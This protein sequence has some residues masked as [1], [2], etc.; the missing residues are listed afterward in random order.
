MVAV[1]NAWGTADANWA[2]YAFDEAGN[3]TNQVDAL[4]RVTKFQYDKL[5]RRIVRRLPSGDPEIYG[6]DSLGNMIAHTNFN[7]TVVTN[8][9]DVMNRLRERGVLNAGVQETYAYSVSGQLTNRVDESGPYSWFHDSRGRVRTNHTPMGA[10]FYDYDRNGNVTNLYSSTV[11]GVAIIY[12]YDALNR[13]TNVVDN[14]LSGVK[15]TSYRFD[16]V[17]N[18]A[19]LQYPNGVTNVWQYDTRNRLTNEVWKLNTTTLASFFYKL[20]VSSQRTNLSEVVNGTS[21]NFAWNYDQ[22]YRLTNEVAGGLGNLAYKYDVV[23]NRTNR[24]SSV[25][26]LA[27]QTPAYTTNDW[28]TADTYDLNGNTTE[29]GSVTYEYDWANRLTKA[30]YPTVIINHN[31]EGHR[32]KKLTSTGWKYYLVDT[33]NPSGYAQV[34]EEFTQNFG[35]DPVLTKVYTYGLDLISERVPDTSTNFFG[36]D[37]HGSTRFLTDAGGGVA[38]AF[39]YDA[40]GTLIAS[41]GLAQTDYLYCG[42]QFDRDLG[43]YFLRARYMKTDT[44]RFWTMDSYEGNSGDPLSL[45]KYLYCHGDS[46]NDVD[47]SGRVVGGLTETVSVSGIQANSRT[48]EGI[49]V[50]A[51]KAGATRAISGYILKTGSYGI[52]G[53]DGIQHCGTNRLCGRRSHS[54]PTRCFVAPS[55]TATKDAN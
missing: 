47:P 13:L 32:F 52:L 17:G 22:Q 48:L 54:Q 21:R 28:L 10:L 49:G 38:N 40:Y 24:A 16:A 8:A 18:L 43:M 46:V 36:Y 35:G 15:N 39:T 50:A 5:G 7:G 20:A 27:N 31:A 42:E 44:G 45:H 33:H 9:Y 14:R 37:G 51:F 2:T 1:T 26:G 11:G 25:S 55:A 4:G 34:L 41:N 30:Y 23:G 12:Q 29:S 6:Y 3:Q 19:S 53:G